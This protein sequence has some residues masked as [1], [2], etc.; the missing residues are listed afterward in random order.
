MQGNIDINKIAKDIIKNFKN[1]FIN[2]KAFILIEALCD[3]YVFINKEKIWLYA[4]SKIPKRCLS[5]SWANDLIPMGPNIKFNKIKVQVDLSISIRKLP[6]I[7]GNSKLRNHSFKIMET[8]LNIQKREDDLYTL[9]YE[10]TKNQNI[11]ENNIDQKYNGLLFKCLIR[12]R[13]KNK[14]IYYNEKLIDLF[15][16]R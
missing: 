6:E 16:D 14:N 8:I 11:G 2:K 7:I 10:N 1:K 3:S 13:E 5:W 12:L 15:K 9:I 4:A